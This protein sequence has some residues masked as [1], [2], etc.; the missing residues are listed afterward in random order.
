MFCAACLRDSALLAG[1]NL[2][3]WD[4]RKGLDGI[5]ARGRHSISCKL[6]K[7]LQGW[8]KIRGAAGGHFCVAGALVILE[9]GTR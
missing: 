2:V 4:R 9:L 7:G 8:V 1:Q 5:F 3:L 6:L